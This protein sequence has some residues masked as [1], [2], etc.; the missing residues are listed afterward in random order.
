VIIAELS[1]E[2]KKKHFLDAFA[3][4][5]RKSTIGLV[6]S[7]APFNPT[8]VAGVDSNHSVSHG[9]PYL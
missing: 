9:R 2:F 6:I 5:L 8:Y 4:R 1:K 3:K 7:V